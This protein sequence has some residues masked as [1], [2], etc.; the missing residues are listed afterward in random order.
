MKDGS[1][2]RFQR[3]LKPRVKRKLDLGSPKSPIAAV[4]LHKKSKKK[5][6]GPE[7]AFPHAHEATKAQNAQ[8]V[9]TP[10]QQQHDYK[11]EMLQKVQKYTKLEAL[12]NS[13][14]KW[15]KQLQKKP[16]LVMTKIIQFFAT[17][18]DPKTLMEMSKRLLDGVND[19][20]KRAEA[21]FWREKLITKVHKVL[22]TP[23][24]QRP[25]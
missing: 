24:Q 22:P 12:V 16:D 6:F 25:E 3:H 21:G 11:K 2:R 9:E 4:P 17:H 1:P 19:E 14:K 18:G 10:M 23:L 13:D 20:Y 5:I 8:E 7:D 15:E